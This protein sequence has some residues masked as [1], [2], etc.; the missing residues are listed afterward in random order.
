MCIEFLNWNNSILCINTQEGIANVCM[1]KLHVHDRPGREGLAARLRVTSKQNWV[2]NEATSCTYMQV[3][4]Q[5]FE[6]ALAANIKRVQVI[7]CVDGSDLS[8][9]MQ[10]SVSYLLSSGNHTPGSATG[11]ANWPLKMMPWV[12]IPP[13][14]YSDCIHQL[15]GGSL[16]PRS[17]GIPYFAWPLKETNL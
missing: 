12:L 4:F 16:V 10:W 15:H 6:K 9:L 17:H 8:H 5:P 1:A 14:A 11:R 13:W 3:W 7:V 2:W